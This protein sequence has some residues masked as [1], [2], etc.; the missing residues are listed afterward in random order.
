MPE[1][2][3]EAKYLGVLFI[4]NGVGAGCAAVGIYLQRGWG[5]W[6][7]AFIAAFSIIN[8]IISRTVG[9][10]GREVEDWNTIGIISLVVEATFILVFLPALYNVRKGANYRSG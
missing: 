1:H 8:Y 5:W 4:L 2:F 6:L 10:P 9:L 3:E 7:G